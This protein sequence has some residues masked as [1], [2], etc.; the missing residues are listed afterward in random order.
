MPSTQPVTMDPTSKG[1]ARRSSTDHER[2]TRLRALAVDDAPRAASEAWAWL[3]E[4]QAPAEHARLPWLF[5]QGTA[6]DGPDG[7]CEGIV[8]N[9]Y[10]EPWLVGMDRLV[11]LGQWLG[12][13]GWTGKTFDAAAGTGFN[14]LTSSSRIAALVAMPTY[15]FT[16]R[17]DELLG[18][19]FDHAIE[20]SPIAPHA[21]V[22]AIRYD[23]P[24]YENPLVL[25]RTRDELVEIVPG[26]YLGRALLRGRYD[27][28]V[29]GY[30]G[31]R[32]PRGGA[33][34]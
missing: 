29:V 18:F 15:A 3:V 27:F 34:R 25:P 4:L 10:G 11:R 32:G 9:L 13:I 31:L 14:R 24:E 1:A 22:R 20:P 16:R 26:V 5:A 30:F 28:Q 8:M 19:R 2:L 12:G 7:D 21:R 17:G 33:H 23:A 6:P